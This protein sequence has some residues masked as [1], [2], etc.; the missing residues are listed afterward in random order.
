MITW[1]LR[2]MEKKARIAAYLAALPSNGRRDDEIAE[3][4][5]RAY[6]GKR[7][8]ARNPI[9]KKG[10]LDE[11]AKAIITEIEKEE[12]EVQGADGSI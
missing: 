1:L 4:V 10:A 8:I 9:R 5:N 12:K 3:L 2:R 6:D 11:Y 7:H